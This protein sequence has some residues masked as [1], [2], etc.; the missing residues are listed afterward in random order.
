M[1]LTT[2]GCDNVIRFYESG[3]ENSGPFK[4]ENLSF[5]QIEN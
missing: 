1:T 3:N 5:T 2:F 4:A